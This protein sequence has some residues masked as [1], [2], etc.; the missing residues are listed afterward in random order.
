MFCVTVAETPKMSGDMHP[1]F[2]HRP[3]TE[4]RQNQKPKL[5]KEISYQKK[6]EKKSSHLKKS[7]PQE[8]LTF[9]N[10]KD[11]GVTNYQIINLPN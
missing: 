9:K 10:I 7:Q 5:S 6:K 11:Q 4:S 2:P 8:R 3:K 1:S